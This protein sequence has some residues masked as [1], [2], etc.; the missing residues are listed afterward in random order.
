MRLGGL[1]L[2]LP[3]Q[4]D[5]KDVQRALRQPSICIKGDLYVQTIE[6]SILSAMNSRTMEIPADWKPAILDGKVTAI[7]GAA[8][9]R[10]SFKVETHWTKLDKALRERWLQVLD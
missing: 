4:A 5:I 8:P 2:G 10:K 6:A 1:Q 3:R 7:N 9:K